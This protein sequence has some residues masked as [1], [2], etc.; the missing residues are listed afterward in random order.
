[1]LH[2]ELR[3]INKILQ[4]KNISQV[5]KLKISEQFFQLPECREAFIFI[6]NYSHNTNT[7]GYVPSLE[8][9]KKRFPNFQL[10]DEV[11]DDIPVLCEELRRTYMQ[12]QLD[13]LLEQ[14][15]SMRRQD[16]YLA[17]NFIH[18]NSSLMMSQ[19][20]ANNMIYDAKD[21]GEMLIEAMEQ[22]STNRGILGIPWPWQSLNEQTMG[23]I[24]GNWYVF[25]GRPK[26]G[27]TTTV[28]QAVA[29]MFERHNKRIGIFNFEDS[30]VDLLMLFACYL[31]KVDFFLCK[32]GLLNPADRKRYTEVCRELKQYD[33]RNGGKLFIVEQ[34]HGRD[35][36]H[37]QAKIQEYA[38]DVAVV[39]GV[40]FVRNSG[41]TRVEVKWEATTEVSR[42][43]KQIA[44]QENCAII[45]ITQANRQDEVGYSD[46]FNQDCDALVK[47][48]KYHF[49]TAQGVKMNLLLVRGGGENTEFYVG[50]RPGVSIF[51]IDISAHKE[52]TKKPFTFDVQQPKFSKKGK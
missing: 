52:E 18:G 36:N 17:L 12:R 23:C 40:Y 24:G 51:E 47:V 37:I 15:D 21:C 16:P 11:K 3:L 8:E 48:E 46:A 34:S 49:P 25:Y 22:A 14:G 41:A 10:L 39:N 43:F 6:L 50:G 13:E 26:E 30:E 5:E 32:R 1:M 2:E 4:V 31:A 42:A 28:V 44:K 20:T 9:F 38:L 27:K 35:P 29:D 33:G 19:H 45:G 7:L